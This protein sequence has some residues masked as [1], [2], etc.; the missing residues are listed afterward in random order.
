MLLR[1][2]SP[3]A[4]SRG[5]M[6]AGRAGGG[7]GGGVWGGGGG[8]AGGTGVD[9]ITTGCGFGGG[10]AQLKSP[11]ALKDANSSRKGPRITIASFSIGRPMLAEGHA[12]ALFYRRTS[13]HHGIFPVPNH[14]A[15]RS[16]Q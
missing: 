14:S 12:K 4:G 3:V 2:A 15:F 7:G 5:E 16:T 13:G 1:R 9:E 8:G 11:N 10:A 6:G